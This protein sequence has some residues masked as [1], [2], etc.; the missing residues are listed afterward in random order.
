M[1]D[2]AQPR[3]GRG[4]GG[5]DRAEHCCASRAQTAPQLRI[6]SQ[7]GAHGEVQRVRGE[8]EF[9]DGM[10]LRAPPS[11]HDSR[12]CCRS[13]ERRAGGDDLNPFAADDRA[14]VERGALV[15]R[16]FLRAVPR[17]RPAKATACRQAGFPP[18]PPLSRGQTQDKT[19]AQIFEVVTN[20]LSTMPRTRRRCR[21]RI[22]GRRSCT[23]GRCRRH[24]RRGSAK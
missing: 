16:Q 2:G 12:G 6:L 22:D 14:A 5:V 11:R 19:D 20:G 8:S 24:R 15:Y 21:A 23:C 4:A 17:G 18:P 1:R 3:P 7:H 13:G 10:T 9:T